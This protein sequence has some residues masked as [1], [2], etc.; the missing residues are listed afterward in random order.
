MGTGTALTTAGI[1]AGAAE[2]GVLDGIKE[3]L[4]NL[5]QLQTVVAPVITA[6]Q[7]GTKNA[8]WVAVI[9]G[10]GWLWIRGRDVIL[11]RLEAHRTGANLGR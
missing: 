1:V 10:G 5:P 9:I 2:T 4:G 8:L 11:A 7:W 6:V 3:L